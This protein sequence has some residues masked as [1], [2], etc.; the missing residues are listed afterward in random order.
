MHYLYECCCRTYVYIH[1]ECRSVLVKLQPTTVYRTFC[2]YF[3]DPV[4]NAIFV[5]FGLPIV[6]CS[7]TNSLI[8][9]CLRPLVFVLNKFYTRYLAFCIPPQDV[10]PLDLLSE[11]RIQHGAI[12]PLSVTSS[13]SSWIFCKGIS[14]FATDCPYGVWC[15]GLTTCLLY[16]C[17]L[18]RNRL[19]NNGWAVGLTGWMVTLHFF[20]AFW[21]MQLYMS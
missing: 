12:E 8:P 21:H 3:A 1:K 15:R 13:Y 16:V 5:F 17:P 7:M 19:L 20:L 6:S 14:G 9:G 18:L 11:Y 4:L 2:F 10:L